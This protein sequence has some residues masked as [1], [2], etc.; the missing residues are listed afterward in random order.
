MNSSFRYQDKILQSRAGLS[1]VSCISK[2]WDATE[3]MCKISNSMK[4][5]HDTGGREMNCNKFMDEFLNT[6][7]F[8]PIIP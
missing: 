8:N 2:Y 7:N 5:F 3:H 4:M 6:E 1:N